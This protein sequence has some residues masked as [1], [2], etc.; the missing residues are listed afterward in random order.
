MVEEQKP[1]VNHLK[2]RS[3]LDGGGKG[4]FAEVRRNS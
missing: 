2:S 1:R 3:F 4:I